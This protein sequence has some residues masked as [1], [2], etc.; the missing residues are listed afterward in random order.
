MVDLD[1][2]LLTEEQKRRLA[3]ALRR[4]YFEHHPDAYFE[5]DA[6]RRDLLDHAS[7][8]YEECLR[9]I[10]PWVLRHVDLAS[11]VVLEIGSGSG[12]SAAAFARV[13]GHVHGYELVE[14]NVRAARARHEV[15]GIENATFHRI[16][17]QQLGEELAR[18][19][20]EGVDLVLLYAVLEHQL[21]GER[22]DTLRETWTRLRPGGWMVVGDTPNRLVYRHEHTSSLPFF[23]MLPDDLALRFSQKSPRQGFRDSMERELQTSR[24][25]ALETLARWG[26]GVSFHE[27]EAVLGS[28]GDLVVAD[29][30]EEPL[31]WHKAVTLEEELLRTYLR[32]RIPEVPL[33]FSRANL[34]L[35]LRKPDGRRAAPGADPGPARR[36]A[37][38]AHSP[39]PPQGRAVPHAGPSRLV[40]ASPPGART[41]AREVVARL[42]SEHPEF[43]Q[44]YVRYQEQLAHWRNLGVFGDDLVRGK[45]V[46]DWECGRGIFSAIFLELGAASVTGIDGWL[47]E[48]WAKQALARL[49][50]ARFERV[51]IREFRERA[52]RRFDLILANTVTE[53]LPELAEQLAACCDLLEP[54]GV[55]LNNH[56]NYY[57]PAGAHDHG[58]LN[59]GP[60][61]R[62][63]FQGPACWSDPRRCEASAEFRR[64]LRERM[65]WTWNE[66][67]EAL[68]DPEE[69][70]ACPY[71]RRAQPW[72]HLVYH[73]D[74]RR[75]F[76]QVGFTTGYPGRSSLNK[77]TLFQLRQ[78]LLEAGFVIESWT[79]HRCANEPPPF[80]TRPPWSLAPED[81]RTCTVVAACRKAAVNPYRAGGAVVWDVPAPDPQQAE[82]KADEIGVGFAAGQDAPGARATHLTP[83][84]ELAFDQKRVVA[85]ELNGRT[86]L[87]LALRKLARKVGRLG[88]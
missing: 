73:D 45:H 37:E 49:P 17:P 59:H 80:L 39:A 34:D 1:R 87:G 65:P 18:N 3:E 2:F 68:L 75:S 84:R 67:T 51:S 36:R 52:D 19:H 66:Q 7:W 58:F 85:A 61:D 64:G 15:L 40:V 60:G 72:A 56:D 35:I 28:L 53:H 82:R 77:I 29:G 55:F 24:E 12:S 57:Q 76:P 21:I 10:L 47:H 6:G 83:R 11:A 43:E 32:E 69:C 48:D 22:L 86:L 38:A 50:D 23:D 8:R 26:R 41:D 62:V 16:D 4:T 13:A 42:R 81:L 30:Y 74:F 54:G 5:T 44:S 14:K 78:W 27:F 70:D 31:V 25:K 33:G 20:P 63:A 46:L 79:P 9:F 88:R 71:F